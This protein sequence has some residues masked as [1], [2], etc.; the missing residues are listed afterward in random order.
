MILA[1]NISFQVGKACLLNRA[2]FRFD[3]PEFIAVIGPNGAG[4]S[5]LLQLLSGF[6][7]PTTGSV[8]INGKGTH[9]WSASEFAHFRAYLQ[10]Q[11][12]VFESFTVEDVLM[13]GRTIHVASK[14]GPAD[15]EMVEKML[16]Q[17]GLHD[18]RTQAFNHLSGGEQQ[19][20]QFAR[21][22]L[23]LKDVG[24]DS[25]SGKILFLDEPLNNLDLYYQYN[26]LQL[27]RTNVVEQQGTVIAVLHDINM[28]YQFADRIIVLSKGNTICDAPTEEALTPELLSAVY[29]MNIQKHESGNQLTYFSASHHV[30]ETITGTLDEVRLQH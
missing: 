22:L 4:K 21:T 19:R 20:I 11:Q 17:L 25:L 15:A 6:Y 3:K 1:E 28:A 26:L 24:S 14:P 2:S 13:M 5:T 10:Q 18:R 12:S 16:V 7:K 30:S 27:A 29:N 23:Q 9:L 8:L